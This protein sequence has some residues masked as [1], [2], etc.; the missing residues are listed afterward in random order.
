MRAEYISVSNNNDATCIAW[1]AVQQFDKTSGGAWTGDIGYNCGQT[2]YNS[3]E[4]AGKFHDEDGGGDYIPKCTWID[5]DHTNSIEI[6]ALKFD[7][8]AYGENV[9]D[10]VNSDVC[11]PTIYAADSEPIA[12][13]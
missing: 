5:G 10:T 2:W 1:I 8:V 11:A 6:A 7:V 3:V 4:S 12:G 9:A 13:Q